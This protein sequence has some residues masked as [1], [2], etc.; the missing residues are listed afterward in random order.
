MKR[1]ILIQV[2]SLLI[3]L[4]MALAGARS[5]SARPRIDHLPQTETP[6]SARFVMSG[7]ISS[8][9]QT[10]PISGSGAFAGSN[11]TVD[12][13][14]TAPEGATSR[15]DKITASVIVLGDKLYFKLG[16][17]GLEDDDEWYVTDIA[18]VMGMPGSII[19]MPGS[20]TDVEPILDAAVKSKEIGKETIA[21]AQT[22]RYQIDVD[23]MQLALAAGL[24]TEGTEDSTLS[25]LL[26]V[27]DD[28]KYVHQ[29]T[30]MLSVSSTSGDIT[31]S[32]SMDLTMTFSD[33]NAPIEITAPPNATPID[34]GSNPS[35]IGAVPISAG[36][37]L[38][39]M[40]SMGTAG[41][42]A[43]GKS[44]TDSSLPLL[45][46]LAVSMVASGALLLYASPNSRRAEDRQA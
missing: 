40:G 9:G 33:F 11:G 35:I 14:L 23:L 36:G 30:L 20:M 18:A 15:P 10:I 24:P 6:S 39:G 4:G 3:A 41:M 22:T 5:V 34:L 21:G 13:T 7:S 25:M 37:P 12:L 43:T 8:E 16:G 1:R 27:G 17:L 38:L 42:P 26:W 45:L 28:D 46:I 44:D 2:L 32:L 31:V 29:F 19:G